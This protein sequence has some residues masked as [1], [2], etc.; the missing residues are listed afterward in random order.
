M[1]FSY[2]GD[3]ENNLLI[4]KVIH[5]IRIFIYNFYVKYK[6]YYFK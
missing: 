1:N 5:Y 4:Y 3:I 2:P 6:K